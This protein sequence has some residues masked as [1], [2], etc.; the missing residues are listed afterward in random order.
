MG[1]SG[2]FSSAGN[3]SGFGGI[4]AGKGGVTGATVG[5]EVVASGFRCFLDTN[6]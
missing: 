2:I 4:E 1:V 3:G 5:A 6:L